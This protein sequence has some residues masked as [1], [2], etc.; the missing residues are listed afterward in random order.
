ML[1][2]DRQIDRRI[3]LAADSLEAAGW[4]VTIVA[5]PLDTPGRDDRRVVRIGTNAGAA[6]R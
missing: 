2:P 4:D 3:L 6:N 5:M 1:T